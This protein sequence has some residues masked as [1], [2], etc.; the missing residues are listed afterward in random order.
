VFFVEVVYG[1]LFQIEGVPEADLEPVLLIE[2]PRFLFP[3][4]RR[5]IA[6]ATVEGGFPPFLLEPI[7]FAAVY[8]ARKTG[9][10]APAQG[11]A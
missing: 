7:D 4:A 2:C 11:N 9:A 8:M 3:F 5:V 10:D 6:D 1:G